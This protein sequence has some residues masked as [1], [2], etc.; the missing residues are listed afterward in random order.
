VASTYLIRM[1]VYGYTTV[2]GNNIYPLIMFYDQ[3][4]ERI[5]GTPLS[6]WPSQHSG[7]GR[8]Y[9]F[10]SLVPPAAWTLY[11]FTMGPEGAGAVPPDAKFVSWGFSF[12]NN[13]G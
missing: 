5:T 7:S 12:G 11:T 8:R 13:D 6:G 3:S 10:G 9:P 2:P 4:G 1:A